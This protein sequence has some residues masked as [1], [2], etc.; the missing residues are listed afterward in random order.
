MRFRQVARFEMIIGQ[1]AHIEL[2]SESDKTSDVIGELWSLKST[3]SL[4]LVTLTPVLVRVDEA[5]MTSLPLPASD[6]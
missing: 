5:S 2:N 3:S 6:T 4:S 1:V